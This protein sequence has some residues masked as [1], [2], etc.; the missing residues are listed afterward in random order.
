VELPKSIYVFELVA[1]INDLL[2]R[3][4]KI[5]Y[6]KLPESIYQ[7]QDILFKIV[8]DISK[9]PNIED[10]NWDTGYQILTELSKCIGYFD[11]KNKDLMKTI[12]NEDIMT[13]WIPAINDIYK[14]I[15][16]K[17][18]LFAKMNTL[19]NQLLEVQ[20]NDEIDTQ[21][22]ISRKYDALKKE[23]CLHEPSLEVWCK[24][25]NPT[26]VGIDSITRANAY[27]YLLKD[28]L[29]RVI[30]IKTASKYDRIQDCI[31]KY[32]MYKT[33]AY[34]S[35]LSVEDKDKIQYEL[36]TTQFENYSM[37]A[38]I[39][40]N[41]FNAYLSSLSVDNPVEISAKL[42]TY[43]TTF[44]NLYKIN[45]IE[46][47]KKEEEIKKKNAIEEKAI[48]EKAIEKSKYLQKGGTIRYI[49]VG[50]DTRSRQLI[51]KE[52][53]DEFKKMNEEEIKWNQ[54]TS[55]DTID[56]VNLNKPEVIVKWV[57]LINVK[58]YLYPGDT[59]PLLEQASLKCAKKRDDIFDIFSDIKN[60][61]F[62]TQKNKQTL[63]IL[64]TDTV[65]N[66]K[67]K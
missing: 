33:I 41:E 65:R 47:N 50:Q 42:A 60:S 43:N 37:I 6:N 7:Q 28:E 14:E 17:Y 21:F 19:Y 36:L 56:A 54:L 22:F 5:F 11:E 58:L 26:A 1:P 13:K 30:N 10:K 67:K 64:K 62:K 44:L 29:L 31:D 38:K 2:R 52:Q 23:I 53:N 12:S 27:L 32:N 15:Y 55:S 46:N 9:T 20:D 24:F 49:E 57:Y 40:E 61:L 25:D 34:A 3:L 4:N 59:I 35:I 18:F 48:E 51:E 39:A 66:N 63:G 8:N 16:M 45:L